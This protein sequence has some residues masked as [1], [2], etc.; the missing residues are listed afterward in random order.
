M[1]K[2]SK[3]LSAWKSRELELYVR[4]EVNIIPL[5]GVG[6][7][8]LGRR[9]DKEGWYP[10]AGAQWDSTEAKTEAGGGGGGLASYSV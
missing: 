10:V 2:P 1:E 9:E 4:R 7:G 8:C 6:W 5:P 3:V